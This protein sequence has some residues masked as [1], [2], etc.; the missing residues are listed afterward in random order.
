MDNR[1]YKMSE[2][3]IDALAE[4][5][6]KYGEEWELP[7]DVDEAWIEVAWRPMYRDASGKL[8]EMDTDMELG[9]IELVQS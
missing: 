2:A 7:T 8:H 6:K 3:A 9:D 1:T 5:L 4:W